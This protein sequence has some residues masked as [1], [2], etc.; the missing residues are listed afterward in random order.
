VNG[1]GKGSV[2]RPP[3]GTEPVQPVTEWYAARRIGRSGETGPGAIGSPRSASSRRSTTAVSA[4]RGTVTWTSSAAVVAAS[5]VLPMVRCASCRMSSR[6]VAASRSVTSSTT[7]ASPSTRPVPPLSRKT[8]TEKVI[9]RSGEVGGWPRSSSSRT[10][11][12]VSSTPWAS[13]VSESR[14]SPGANSLARCHSTALSGRPCTP[15]AAG[16]YRIT[17][18]SLSRM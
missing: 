8:D 1:V 15:E 7:A 12:P 9:R 14:S 10:G 11:I 3:G 16:L 4:K 18:R 6:S 2:S 17:R 13:P 5:R